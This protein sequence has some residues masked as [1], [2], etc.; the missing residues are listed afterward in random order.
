MRAVVYTKLG[1]A[2]DVLTLQDLEQP[3]PG[4]GEVLVRVHLPGVSPSDVKR[5]GR[6]CMDPP[7]NMSHCP[8]MS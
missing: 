2:Q 4:P 1:P 7:Q 5:R 8:R 3:Q 6:G